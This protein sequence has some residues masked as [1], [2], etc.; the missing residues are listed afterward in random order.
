MH[1]DVRIRP[2]STILIWVALL[3]FPIVSAAQEYVDPE[4]SCPTCSQEASPR[5]GLALMGGYGQ[6]FGWVG[7]SVDHYFA[8]GLLSGFLS[9]GYVPEKS[10]VYR[11]PS[12]PTGAAGIRAYLLGSFKH[13]GFLE[14]SVTEVSNGVKPIFDET[15]ALVGSEDVHG[16]GPGFQLGYRF[17]S[18]GGFTLI[19]Q[20]GVG[21]SFSEWSQSPMIG[22]GFGYTWP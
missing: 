15:G 16:Y 4:A 11:T 10:D 3:A 20:G 13:R 6:S 5:R 22:L 17:S 14:V 21:Y 7:V 18:R 2:A 8:D 1:T 12:G 19:A 9:A